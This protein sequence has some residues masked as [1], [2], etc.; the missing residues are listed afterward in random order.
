MQWHLFTAN[1]DTP[2]VFEDQAVLNQAISHAIAN[3]KGP[4]VVHRYQHAL[5]DTQVYGLPGGSPVPTMLS[6]VIPVNSI[7]IT[8]MVRGG[9]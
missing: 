7:A 6:P 2:T 8:H 5:L 3:G 9:A 4:I 1:N